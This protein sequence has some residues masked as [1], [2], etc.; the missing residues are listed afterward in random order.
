MV[1]L[2]TGAS[3]GFGRLL[4][5]RLAASGHR[6]FGTSRYPAAGAA[7][8]TLVPLDV[9]D[10]AS[11]AACVERVQREGGTVDVLVNNAGYVHEGPFEELSIDDLKGIF[12]TN[13]FGAVRMTTAVL[14][15]MRARRSGRIINISS[16]AGLMAA[17][18]MGAYCATKYALESFSDSLHQEVKAF[19][20]AVH[21]VEPGFFKTG[22]ASRILRTTG[23]IA[24]YDA[25]RTRMY[26]ALAR[27]EANAPGPEPVVDL[28]ASL[29]EGRQAGLRHTI[30]RG[31]SMW[32]V[33]GLMPGWLWEK[34]LRAKFRLD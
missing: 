5:E 33:R 1:V 13:F 8:F 3:S 7:P 22:I 11:V 26:D 21:V 12:E 20:I 30:G 10:D 4:A 18:F 17:P 2:I 32:R 16:L 28:L 9:R 23:A 27:E 34:G 6:V 14:P 24:D 31:S 15:G 25:Q 19:G 29:V